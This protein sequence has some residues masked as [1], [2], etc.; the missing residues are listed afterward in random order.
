MRILRAVPLRVLAHF[1]QDAALLRA[2]QH[3]IDLHVRTA[4]RGLGIAETDVTD[5]QR[6]LGKALNFGIVFGQ[7]SYGLVDELGISMQ[8]VE[9]LLTAHSRSLSWCHGVGC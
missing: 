3:S 2:F 5:Q 9:E 1:S 8:R 4:A 6:Q 7:T